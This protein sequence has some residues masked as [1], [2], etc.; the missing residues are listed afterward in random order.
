MVADPYSFD[1]DPD[2][3]QHFRL[4][5][6][7]DPDP[8]RIQG[9]WW[10]KIEKNVQQKKNHI[11]L[12]K[13]YHTIHLSLGFQKGRPSYKRSLQLLKE[14]IH[15]F[16]TWNSWF[17]SSFVGHFSPPGSGFRIGIRIHWP[18][19]IRIRNP[20]FKSKS[21]QFLCWKIVGPHSYFQFNLICCDGYHGYVSPFSH[22][23]GDYNFKLRR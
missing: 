16:K 13:N 18:D 8:I 4:N 6:D 19:W 23:L 21:L 17:F 22:S 20:A 10:P 11:F 2:Q 7:P 12:D 15:H 3:I 5:T 14:N 1:T 9:F